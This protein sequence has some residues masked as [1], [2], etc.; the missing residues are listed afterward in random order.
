M[1]ADCGDTER[2]MMIV[3]ISFCVGV[4]ITEINPSFFHTLPAIIKDVFASN[5][6]AGVF[7]LSLLLDLFLPKKKSK[8]IS[9]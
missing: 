6:V 1:V 4:G 3:A 5:S 2:N 8:T 7:V 9:T